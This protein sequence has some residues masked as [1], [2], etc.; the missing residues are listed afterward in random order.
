[1]SDH[2]PELEETDARQGQTG[3]GL[4]WVLRISL[5]LIVVAFVALWLAYAHRGHEQA[6]SAGQVGTKE[7]S[8]AAPTVSAPAQTGRQAQGAG[9]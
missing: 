3:T 4:R 8:A 9:G 2:G 5:A 1:M 6:V 7:A